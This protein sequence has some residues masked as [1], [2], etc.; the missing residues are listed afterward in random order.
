MRN[1]PIQEQ[2]TGADVWT[3]GKCTQFFEGPS[4]GNAPTIEEFCNDI[5][6]QD[7]SKPIESYPVEC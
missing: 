2:S 5:R 6:A 7:E 4:D 3:E 1:Q